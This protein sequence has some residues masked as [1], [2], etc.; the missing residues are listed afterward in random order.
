MNRRSVLI[1]FAALALCVVGYYA[2]RFVTYGQFVESTDDAYVKA[3]TTAIAAR[4]SGYVSKVLVADNQT[5]RKGDVLVAIDDA[6]FKARVEQ[7]Q[8]AVASKKAV[9]DSMGAKLSLEERLIEAAEAR[10][11]SAVADQ[12]RASAD[13]ARAE[14]LRNSGSGSKQAY[15]AALAES[16]KADAA[17]ES[18]KAALAAEREQFT[19][20]ESARAQNQADLDQAA[21]ALKL[22]QIDLD[23]TLVRAPYDGVAGVRT[24]QDGQYVRAGAQL[25]AVVRLPDVYVLANFKET[26]A[27]EMRRGQP[28]AVEIDAFPGVVFRGRI[29]SFSPATGSEFS[30]L[31]PENATGNFTKVVQRL[32][33]KVVLE[34]GEDTLGY[35]RPGMSAVVRVDTREEGD[36]TT[37]VLAPAPRPVE[38]AG[39]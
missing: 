27:G 34:P 8:A 18:A 38:A 6:D 5:V 21:A 1:A 2:F 3:D 14:D 9:L 12:K 7:A 24:V 36:G 22:A 33:V 4:V 15:D 13:L 26:Q 37:A 11:A 29:D 39:R 23:H 25:M 32:P 19:V 28:V 10:V 30:L 31:P 35:L 17:V 16:R 20:V